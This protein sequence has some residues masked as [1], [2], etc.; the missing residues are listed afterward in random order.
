MSHFD[1]IVAPITGLANAAVAIVRVS[2][3]DAWHIAQTVFGPW[4]ESPTPRAAHFGTFAHGDEGFALPFE[5]GRSYTGEQTVEFSIHGSPAS[6]LALCQACLAA[7]AR[8]AEPGEFTQRA[9]LNGR[10]DLSQAEGVRDTIE[11]ET[12]SQL[13]LARLHR[14]GALR[15][16]VR[17][18]RER[19]LGVQ[20]SIEA[21]VDFSDEVGE[22]DKPE[23]L[24][25]L[26]QVARNVEELAATAETG[27]ILRHGLRVAIVGRPNAGKSSLLNALLG[28]DRAIVTDVPGTTRDF[29]EE[30]ADL[31][32][33]P[34]VLTDTAGLR[35]TDDPVE[36][37][38]VERARNAAAAADRVWYVADASLGWTEEDARQH[39]ALDRPCLVLA[40]KCDLAPNAGFGRPVSAT[41]GAGLSDLIATLA[42]DLELSPDAPAVNARHAASLAQALEGVNLATDVLRADRPTD[43]ASV[44]LQQASSALGAIT[45]ETADADLVDRLFADFCLGK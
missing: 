22:L 24:A 19:V 21:S 36:A 8:R 11:A 15:N 38:G 14:E 42:A 2:G 9:F 39:A 27:R 13:R 40:N 41:T 4:P 23:A 10:I 5:E 44:G 6:V 25:A 1:T 32:G 30:R 37:L 20:A 34:C 31:G 43:L 18:I 3:P 35:E 26:A 17:A 45:G 12:Q 28:T 7:G 16:R 33:I 29:L